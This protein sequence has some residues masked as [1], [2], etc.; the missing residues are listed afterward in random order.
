MTA[1]VSQDPSAL[2]LDRPI[3][4]ASRE[5]ARNKE[6]WYAA[7]RDEAPVA[8]GRISLMRMTLVSRY[9][10]CR[11]VLTDERFVRNRARAMG[12]PGG[13][14]LPFPLPKSIAALATSMIYED[15]PEHRRHRNLVNQAVLDPA[16][17]LELQRREVQRSGRDRDR[18]RRR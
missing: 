7:M 18:W 16:V 4:L 12:K 2:R 11:F 14:A 6:A 8:Q 3:D 9:E 13:G 10:D 1:A 17:R 5:F 15:D